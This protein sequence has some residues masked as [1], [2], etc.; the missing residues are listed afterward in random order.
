MVGTIW[1]HVA[2]TLTID[3]RSS[4]YL[5]FYF[6]IC[7]L[8]SFLPSFFSSFLSFFLLFFLPSFP[9]FFL[10]GAK[11][12]FYKLDLNGWGEEIIRRDLGANQDLSFY[13]WNNDMFILFCC[14]T[15]C[16]YLEKVGKM[17]M[18]MKTAHKY[19]SKYRGFTRLADGIRAAYPSDESFDVE[20]FLKRLY[21]SLMTFKHQTVPLTHSLTHTL[22]NPNTPAIT[23]YPNTSHYHPDI[24]S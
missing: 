24:L 11:R 10:L 21:M 9:L 14:L 20:E 4:L 3:R 17:R 7:P 18:G 12:V 19:V 22:L 23:P 13:N 16:D 5:H 2:D 8:P 15:G 1:V 6:S